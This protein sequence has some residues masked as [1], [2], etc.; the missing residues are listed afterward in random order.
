MEDIVKE[1]ENLFEWEIRNLGSLDYWWPFLRVYVRCALRVCKE[2]ILLDPREEGGL[3]MVQSLMKVIPSLKEIQLCGPKNVTVAVLVE[4]GAKAGLP[5][6][7][8][9]VEVIIAEIDQYDNYDRMQKQNN[10]ILRING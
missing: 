9:K 1:D 10:G 6:P 4:E 3:E 8:K 2:V 7:I 5:F